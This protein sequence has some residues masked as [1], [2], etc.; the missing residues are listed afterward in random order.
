MKMKL[1][2]WLKANLGPRALA[3]LCGGE[4]NVLEACGHIAEAMSMDGSVNYREAFAALVRS[5]HKDACRA[6]CYHLIARSM[7]WEDRARIWA[8]CGLEPIAPAVLG[9]CKYEP[10]SKNEGREAAGAPV[11]TGACAPGGRPAVI[12]LGDTHHTASAIAAVSLG[13]RLLGWVPNIHDN[14]CP[15]AAVQGALQMEG[16][17]R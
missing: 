12:P 5:M 6:L 9:R 15:T 13:M 1:T 11:E 2:S 3:P 8:A 7:D 14:L 4:L 16:G 10:I 17:A